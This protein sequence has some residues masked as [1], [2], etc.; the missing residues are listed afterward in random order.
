MVSQQFLD[1][2]ELAV[3]L[4]LQ[5]LHL[6]TDDGVDAEVHVIESVLVV[7]VEPVAHEVVD[8][9]AV[10][11]EGDVANDHGREHRQSLLHLRHQYTT[12]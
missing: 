4:L 8:V 9:D 5:C 7:D 12:I 1:A 10:G 3:H 2:V 6:R 11:K